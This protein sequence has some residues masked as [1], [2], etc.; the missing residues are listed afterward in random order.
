MDRGKGA[1]G[2]AISR[3]T[4]WHELFFNTRSSLFPKPQAKSRR[5]FVHGTALPSLTNP[6]PHNKNAITAP[7]NPTNP[8]PPNLNASP[9]FFVEPGVELPLAVPVPAPVFVLLGVGL[10]VVIVKLLLI[11]V[12]AKLLVLFATVIVLVVCVVCVIVVSA[13]VAVEEEPPPPPPLM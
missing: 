4:V 3:Q 6:N 11:V 8:I 9:A 5:L 1:F 10:V 13:F 12:V 7:P 2:F